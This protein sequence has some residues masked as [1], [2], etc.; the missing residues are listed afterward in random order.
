MTPLSRGISVSYCCDN[1]AKQ[2]LK[3]TSYKNK[4]L[5]SCLFLCLQVLGL[6]SGFY[7][8][9][10]IYSPFLHILPKASAIGGML[11]SW[12]MASTQDAKP[13]CANMFKASAHIASGL[14][15]YHWPKQVGWPSPKLVWQENIL[16]SRGIGKWLDICWIVFQSSSESWVR[17]SNGG[18]D[19]GG[20][21]SNNLFSGRR[22]KVI[23]QSTWWRHLCHHLP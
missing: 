15:T 17:V 4:H 1:S 2:A 10:Q 12:Q 11:F 5:F 3:F 9:S 16:C 7:G 23:W 6:V 21:G 14:F 20:G 8:L 19:D 22:C 18:S 13:N